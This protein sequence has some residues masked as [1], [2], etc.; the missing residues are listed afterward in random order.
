MSFWIEN[1]KNN[2]P[3]VTGEY[4]CYYSSDADWDVLEWDGKR[5]LR[6][7]KK[8]AQPTHWMML[9]SPEKESE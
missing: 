9:S 3:G 4:V 2:R 1:R 5:F 7:G 6:C 8:T